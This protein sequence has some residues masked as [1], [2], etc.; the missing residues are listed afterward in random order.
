[1]SHGP[2]ILKNVG[3]SLSHKCCFSH[4]S[5]QIYFG[6]KIAIIGRNGSGKST[7]LK[8]LQGLIEPTEGS[9]TIPPDSVCG[10]VSQTVT[11]G[12]TLSGGQRF[13]KALSQALQ[14]QPDILFLDEPTNHLDVSNRK[15]L[16]GMLKRFTGTLIVVSHDV[17]LL[18]TCINTIWH[19]DEEQIKIFS[20]SY[21][22]YLREQEQAR[23]SRTKKI[24]QLKKEKRAAHDALQAEQQRA[25]HNKKS[26]RQENDRN[27]RG[28]MKESGSR[29]VGKN[30]G[31]IHELSDR[32]AHELSENFVPEEIVPHFSLSATELSSSKELVSVREG[33]C[34]YEKPVLTNITFSLCAQERVALEGDNGSGKSTF[35]KALLRDLVVEV[36]G[37]WQMPS[38]YDIGYL[39][40]HYTTLNPER[41]V[42]EIL[43][44]ATHGWTNVQ[45]RKHLNDF[46]FR[47]NEE[48]AAP[49]KQLSGGEKVRLSLAVIAAQTPKLLLLDELTNNLDLETREH[50]IQVLKEYPGAI[51]AI[52]H[53]R[54]FLERISIQRWYRVGSGC[55]VEEV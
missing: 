6:E 18:R 55:L 1:M 4:F 35:F 14:D 39:D 51:L 22:E 52:S 50:V 3:F 40:Q 10:F 53:D 32:I 9:V 2:L 30:Q 26:G 36:S 27:I 49:V 28:A 43:Q 41:S 7:L 16:M 34:G 13:N 5:A 44:D 20:G 12:D 19:I 29:T 33:A 45:I 23:A 37:T 48:V 11:Q 24:E 47:K 17:E 38:A 46:L 25:A 21:E 15:S 54:D 31:R 42:F 8:I